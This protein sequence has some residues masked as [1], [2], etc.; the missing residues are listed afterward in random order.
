MRVQD[1]TDQL[2]CART[3]IKEIVI[4]DISLLPI[5]LCHLCWHSLP[6]TC[7]P[8]PMHTLLNPK[9]IQT[10]REGPQYAPATASVHESSLYAQLVPGWWQLCTTNGLPSIRAALVQQLFALIKG[11]KQ[12]SHF[13]LN[14]KSIFMLCP[15]ERFH[16]KRDALGTCCYYGIQ[17]LTHLSLIERVSLAGEYYLHTR[18]L[19]KQNVL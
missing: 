14:S 10:N 13:W 12:I 7:I 16:R 6:A 17:L 11:F 9:G 1:K 5:V 15:N 4:K 2:S 18:L 8:T 3:I 19:N